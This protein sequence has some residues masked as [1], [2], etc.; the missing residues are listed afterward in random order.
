MLAILAG[1]GLRCRTWVLWGYGD[2]SLRPLGG[3]NGEGVVG[4]VEMTPL[5]TSVGI[6]VAW[7]PLLIWLLDFTALVRL[8]IIWLPGLSTH[9]QSTPGRTDTTIVTTQEKPL[10]FRVG[11][12]IQRTALFATT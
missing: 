5:P 1:M 2:G 10:R 12:E 6:L 7:S 9:S 8:L 4:V 3:S 11:S